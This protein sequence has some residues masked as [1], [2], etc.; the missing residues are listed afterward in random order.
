MRCYEEQIKAEDRSCDLH[1]WY[2]HDQTAAGSTRCPPYQWE[3]TEGWKPP[4]RSV[5]ASLP[6]FSLVKILI[7]LG[8]EKLNT[9]WSKPQQSEA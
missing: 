1:P 8:I 9:L 5:A 3:D 4:H 7:E 2:S 6:F